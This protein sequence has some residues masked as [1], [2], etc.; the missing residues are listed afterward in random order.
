MQAHQSSPNRIQTGE[1]PQAEI[2]NLLA[3]FTQQRYAEAQAYADKLTRRFPQ[4]GFTWKALGAIHKK[5]GNPKAAIAALTKASEYIPH[6]ADVHYNLGNSYWEQH[7]LPE[8]ETC[9]RQAL[10]IQPG[11]VA[12]HYNLGKVYQAQENLDAAE[13]CY[14]S[15]LSLQAGFVE[16]LSNLGAVLRAQAKVEEAAVCL[17]RAV[18]IAPN[19]PQHHANLANVLSELGKPEEAESLYRHALG[20]N[21]SLWL[22]RHNLAGLLLGQKR[23]AEAE[24]QYVPLLQL[25]PDFAEAWFQL[26]NCL[27][28]QG[29]HREAEI[30]YREAL[31]VNA[32]YAEAHIHLGIVQREQERLLE[33]EQSYRTALR[34]KPESKAVHNNLG[35]VLRDLDRLVEAE[36]CFL[37][38]LELDPDYLDAQNNLGLALKTA[39]RLE[40]ARLALEKAIAMNPEFLEPH[41]GLATLKT[42][43]EDDPHVALLEQHLTNVHTLKQE[44]Q[45]RFWFAIGKMY[46]DLQRFDESFSAYENGN[47]LKFSAVTW[48]EE[49]EAAFIKRIKGIFTK[50]F[51]ARFKALTDDPNRKSAAER[52]PIFILGMPRSGTSLLEQILSTHSGVFGAGEL[53]SMSD[54]IAAAM[55]DGHFQHF[56]E[57]TA[58]F[59]LEQWQQLGQSYLHKVWELAPEAS[60]ITDKMPVNF[61]YI[62]MMHLM[63]PNAKIIHAMRNPMDSCFSCYS[64]LFHKDNLAYSYDLH[65]LGR[66]CNRYLSLMEHWHAVLPAGTI[67]DCRYEEMVE[68]T[69]VQARRVLE[70][71]GLPWDERCLDF[72]KNKRRV[73]TAS[74]SQVQKPIYKSSVERWKNYEKHLGVLAQQIYPRD[75]VV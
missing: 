54:V 41:V 44:G 9:Y 10:A 69:E 61:L 50:E 42:Y 28:A 26:G 36:A 73:K 17:R 51:F 62:G 64:R 39:G 74:Q 21:P 57:A 53:T 49:N 60:Y 70:Y 72:H 33:A 11:Y 68:H 66:Y 30:A 71:I 34:L 45:M 59:S 6:D 1:P 5:L 63:F 13:S 16:A 55:P 27:Y 20:M 67:L 46:E 19:D 15:A 38:A 7:A 29:R 75:T 48:D 24:S 12:A 22:A 3:L 47:R 52:T 32:D 40:D 4:H 37:R 31:R 2:A 8:A 43:Q 14:R 35:N 18:E 56:P 23:L 25:Q 65:A 58:H